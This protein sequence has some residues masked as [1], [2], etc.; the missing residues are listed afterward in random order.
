MHEARKAIRCAITL[1]QFQ[2]G[3]VLLNKALQSVID[4]TA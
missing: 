4:V 3:E 2:P 1:L